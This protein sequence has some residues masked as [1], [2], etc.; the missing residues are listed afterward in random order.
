MSQHFQH[1]AK[2]RQ[3]QPLFLGTWIVVVVL[4]IT[5]CTGGGGD[6]GS[7]PVRK[8][9]TPQTPANL[10]AIAG[11]QQVTLTW[12]TVPDASGY[13]LYW[14]NTPDVAK[15]SSHVVRNVS[16]GYRHQE[17]TNGQVYFYRIAAANGSGESLP[18]DEI[19]AMP[20]GHTLADTVT[21]ANLR[22]CL[23]NYSTSTPVYA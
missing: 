19:T 6:G 18:S 11:N 13:T 3:S 15:D 10:N 4:L 7:P 16:P 23:T 1:N 21:D 5:A 8:S 2:D 12:G 17:L 22:H 9:A 14:N 20:G